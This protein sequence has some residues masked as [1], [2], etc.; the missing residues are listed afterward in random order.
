MESS[1]ESM[2]KVPPLI[3][4]FPPA[5]RP[6]MLVVSA[7]A[8]SI[9]S[10][11]AGAA[12]SGASPPRPPPRPGPPNPRAASAPLWAPFSLPP[13]VT[14]LKSPSS[15]CII[16]LALIPSPSASMS[17]VPPEIYTKPR[18]VSLSCSLWIP[19]LPDRMFKVVMPVIR[20]LSLA[21]S[22]WEAQEMV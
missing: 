13:P 20:M 7:A 3:S 16:P 22:P 11:S 6:F 2:E 19:S 9:G 8:V 17:N 14:S 18:E 5:F 10:V 1:A 21:F 15:I 12:S 4:R